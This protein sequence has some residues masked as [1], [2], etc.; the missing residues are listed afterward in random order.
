MKKKT[1]WIINS[2]TMGVMCISCVIN[3]FHQTKRAFL[4]QN[5]GNNS[6]RNL[7][8]FLCFLDSDDL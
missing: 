7:C 8:R 4:V 6:S 3:A 5:H 2:V 1:L